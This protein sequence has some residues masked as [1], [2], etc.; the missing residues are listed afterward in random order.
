MGTILPFQTLSTEEGI[1]AQSRESDCLRSQSKSNP[2]YPTELSLR[3]G[4]H[5]YFLLLR[6]GH[7]KPKILLVLTNVGAG[8]QEGS[9]GPGSCCERIGCSMDGSWGR[10]WEILMRMSG[11]KVDIG[12]R[13]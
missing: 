5:L 6:T 4:F 3:S 9:M 13:L 2:I 8:A 1:T 10:E 7:R 11:S 12:Y